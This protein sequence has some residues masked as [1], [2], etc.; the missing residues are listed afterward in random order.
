METVHIAQQ[1]IVLITY[2]FSDGLTNKIRPAL[3]L[4]NNSYNTNTQ[5]I[6]LCALTTQ[7]QRH[8]YATLVQPK[9]VNG[10]LHHTSIARA[11]AVARIHKKHVLK[12]LG[13]V[14]DERFDSI[15]KKLSELIART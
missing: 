12:H 6:I 4:S 3:V 1:D 10:V 15:T 8:P 11:D 2:P 9:D 5:D 14:S 13:T 7:K